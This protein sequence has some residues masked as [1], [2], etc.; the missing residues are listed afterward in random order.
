MKRLKLPFSDSSNSIYQVEFY[1][2]RA[3][4]EVERELFMRFF[5]QRC[6][7]VENLRSIDL[8]EM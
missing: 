3:I 6:L 1:S 5:L 7:V 8:R 4:H 2:H